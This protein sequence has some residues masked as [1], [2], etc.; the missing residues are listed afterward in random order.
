MVSHEYKHES[1]IVMTC[2]TWHHQTVSN[3]PALI[4]HHQDRM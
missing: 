1:I 2:N 4:T 3:L